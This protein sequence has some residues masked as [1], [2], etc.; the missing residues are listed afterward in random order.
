MSYRSTKFSEKVNHRKC[1][2]WTHA[3]RAPELVPL[4]VVGDSVAAPLG[5]WLLG[6][7]GVPL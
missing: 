1:V 3:V 6:I 7:G 2:V 5:S 4:N